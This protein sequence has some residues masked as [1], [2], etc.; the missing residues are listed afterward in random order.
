MGR[1]SNINIVALVIM[2][3]FGMFL[4]WG[5]VCVRPLKR[6]SREVELVKNHISDVPILTVENLFEGD[7]LFE[8]SKILSECWADYKRA[9][10]HK[11]DHLPDPIPFFSY[12]RVIAGPAFRHMSEILPGIFTGS[13]ILGTFFGLVSGLGNLSVQDSSA[14]KSS[15]DI[16]LG[17]MSTAFWTS[18]FGL[19][20]SLFWSYRDRRLIYKVQQG[21]LTIHLLLTQKVPAQREWDLLGQMASSQREQL[22]AF[23]GL[24]SDTLIPQMIEGIKEAFNHTL[25]PQLGET[26][27]VF[28]RFSNMT[29][30]SHIQGIDNISNKILEKFLGAFDEEIRSLSEEMKQVAEWQRDVTVELEDLSQTLVDATKQQRDALE[31]S[32][33]ITESFE[34]QVLLFQEFEDTLSAVQTKIEGHVETLSEVVDLFTQSIEKVQRN[35]E[36]H[37]KTQRQSDEKR[38]HQLEL[39][40]NQLAEMQQFWNTASDQLNQMQEDM[41]V[42]TD[43]LGK[44][45]T[46]GLEYT[47][48]QY[49][50][51]LSESVQR[52]RG[53]VSGMLEATQDFP[54][55]MGRVGNHLRALNETVKHVSDEI[56]QASVAYAASEDPEESEG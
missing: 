11:F 35:Y 42:A 2:I 37:V 32:S 39:S 10:G 5:R 33:K 38:Q 4:Y 17:G 24:A 18:I 53:V 21:L 55:E 30:D 51:F 36:L 52:L 26:T 6:F 54:D 23:K 40:Q 46:Q 28:E 43:M 9:V 48:G 29:A 13:G 50:E 12:D 31:V 45:L 41:V 1:G 14:I 22:A 25:L 8:H 20:F 49:D 16:L 44:E 34:R 7:I 19:A 3:Q 27:K 47:F 15:I 56:K